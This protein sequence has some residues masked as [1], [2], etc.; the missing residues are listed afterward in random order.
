[1]DVDN[2]YC[3]KAIV[4]HWRGSQPADQRKASKASASRERPACPV[5]CPRAACAQLLAVPCGHFRCPPASRISLHGATTGRRSKRAEREDG[6]H[7]AT[8]CVSFALC[9]VLWISSVLCFLCF[10]FAL[11]CFAFALLCFL[12]LFLCCFNR[13]ANGEGGQCKSPRREGR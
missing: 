12:L 8:S 1:M 5:L 4:S 7:I 13:I 6:Q 3:S 11:L 9:S 2:L 10:C